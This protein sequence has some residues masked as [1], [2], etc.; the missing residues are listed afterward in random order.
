MTT[1]DTDTTAPYSARLR[2]ASWDAHRAAEGAPYLEALVA[3][4]L[5]VDG[6]AALV[7]QH[8][9]AYG[10]LEEAAGAMGGAPIGSRFVDPR[11]H[12]TAA[13]RA[14]L[15][16]LL[17]A[18]WGDLVVPN[19]ATTAYCERMREVCFDWAGGFVAHHYVRFLGDLSGGQFIARVLADTYGIGPTSGAAFYDFSELGD[20]TEYKDRYRAE[21][22]A[23]PWSAEEQG[24]IVAEVLEG[25]R[26]NTEVLL[27]PTLSELA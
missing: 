26:C 10:V 18:A 23:A 7:A 16:A 12:R 13:L 15:E 20:L 27:D 22:D 17:G 19:A 14:D 6:V 25:Y 24:R 5:D 3:G 2:D 21:L 9:F 8:Y 4:R 1:T 11:L